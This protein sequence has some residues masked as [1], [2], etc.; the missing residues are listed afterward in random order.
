MSW[1]FAMF[2]VSLNLRHPKVGVHAE[3][4][5]ILVTRRLGNL[6]ILSN[7]FQFSETAIALVVG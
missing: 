2:C 5:N 3:D 1:V 4:F 6:P 7:S